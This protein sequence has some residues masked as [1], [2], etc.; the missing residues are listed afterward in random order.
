MPP[1]LDADM[2]PVNDDT[3]G[4]G[5]VNMVDFQ[6]LQ[7]RTRMLEHNI[8]NINTNLTNLTSLVNKLVQRFPEAS[9]RAG[10]KGSTPGE[11]SSGTKQVRSKVTQDG[12]H[13]FKHMKPPVFS[14]EDRDCNKDTVMTFL[15]KWRDVLNLQ[16][17]EESVR[18][19]EASLSLDGGKAYKWW[20][21]LDVSAQPTTWDEFEKAF[22]KI[23]AGE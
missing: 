5:L 22:L 17:P 15:Q 18:I 19:L 7:E 9:P 20:M 21:S 23:L 4:H 11:T 8:S 16:K 1:D 14:G 13:L 12:A 3:G 2:R 10:T 6:A